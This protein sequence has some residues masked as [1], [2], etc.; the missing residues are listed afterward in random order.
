VPIS[1][2]SILLHEDSRVCEEWGPLAIKAMR[3]SCCV[4][5]AWDRTDSDTPEGSVLLLL[6]ATVL[7]RDRLAFNGSKP[8]VKSIHC[9]FPWDRTF[10]FRKLQSVSM[11]VVYSVRIPVGIPSRL[12][13]TITWQ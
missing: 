10:G 11:D 2:P 12:C 13:P 8:C 3:K 7:S 5:K 9:P 6:R 4:H 1:G